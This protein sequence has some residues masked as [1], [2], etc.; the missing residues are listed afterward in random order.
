MKITFD[1]ISRLY[2]LTILM[3][4]SETTKIFQNMNAVFM[5]INKNLGTLKEGVRRARNE[6]SVLQANW[7]PSKRSLI[8]K[9]SE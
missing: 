3:S 6:R 4:K 9:A 2:R 5:Y 7:K 1:N 8:A